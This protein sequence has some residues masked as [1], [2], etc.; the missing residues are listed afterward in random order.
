MALSLSHTHMRARLREFVDGLFCCLIAIGIAFS[1]LAHAAMMSS[2]SSDSAEHTLM[3][4]HAHHG[5]SMASMVV[6][7]SLDS[8]GVSAHCNQFGESSACTL[9]CSACLSV[10]PQSGDALR[11]IPRDYD[12]L[13]YYAGAN[14]LVDADP[15]LR[16]PRH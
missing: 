7:N 5:D 15:P 13:Q 6:G 16:P 14:V 8:D 9:L 4:H 2:T 12:W 11:G 1:P 10:L 3:E